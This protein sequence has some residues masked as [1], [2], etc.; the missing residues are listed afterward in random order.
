[1][2]HLINNY[3]IQDYTNY[4]INNDYYEIKKRI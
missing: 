2:D 4:T 1:M 3:N